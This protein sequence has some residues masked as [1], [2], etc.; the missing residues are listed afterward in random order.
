MFATWAE[1]F[2]IRKPW[3]I[4]G[5]EEG[6]WRDVLG[7]L[8]LWAVIAHLIILT[9]KIKGSFLVSKAGHTDY[10]LIS[11]KHTFTSTYYRA[12]LTEGLSSSGL[13]I[14]YIIKKIF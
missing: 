7:F 9:H 8:F 5:R 13:S 12:I 2:G 1:S 11:M 6:V 10:E 4:L 14:L 3:A